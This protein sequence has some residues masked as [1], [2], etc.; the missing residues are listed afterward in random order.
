MRSLT[1]FT[2]AA[3]SSKPDLKASTAHH[4]ADRVS[5]QTDC[6]LAAHPCLQARSSNEAAHRLRSAFSARDRSLSLMTAS[7]SVL[8]LSC[9]KQ[10]CTARGGAG[11]QFELARSESRVCRPR[12][13]ATRKTTLTRFSS[14]CFTA[15]IASREEIASA[16]SW[17]SR[18]LVI[19][20]NTLDHLRTQKKTR[21]PLA[22]RTVRHWRSLCDARACNARARGTRTHLGQTH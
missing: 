22:H 14:I 8:H 5:Q 21:A 15:C 16:D 2:V 3:V 12:C 4:S 1:S 18:S 9:C 13:G 10:S 11:R 6:W 20:S 7:N 17:S 19:V